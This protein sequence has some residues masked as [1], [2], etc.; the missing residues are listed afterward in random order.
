M[1]A[2]IEPYPMHP[3]FNQLIRIFYARHGKSLLARLPLAP[4][5]PSRDVYLLPLTIL[6][7]L[8]S[9]VSSLDSNPQASVQRYLY[10]PLHLKRS[11]YIYIV[12]TASPE[13]RLY[14][15][16]GS[17]MERRRR[18][19]HRRLPSRTPCPR[20]HLAYSLRQPHIVYHLPTPLILTIDCVTSYRLLKYIRL[21]ATIPRL[22]TLRYAFF[23]TD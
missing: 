10:K 22:I 17:V 3:D 4:W 6:L 7:L 23:T 1:G 12:S 9:L 5:R 8:L 13:L 15:R 11:F 19:L 16:G 18:S 20:V 2:I 21:A 14:K